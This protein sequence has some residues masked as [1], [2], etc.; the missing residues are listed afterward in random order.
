MSDRQTEEAILVFAVPGSWFLLMFFAGY[1]T[2][3]TAK[4]QTYSTN[5]SAIRLTGPFVTMIY[6]MITGDMLT[7]GIIYSI[8]LFGFSQ[9]FYFLYK[10]FPNKTTLYS[11]YFSTWMA[12]FQITLGNYDVRWGSSPVEFSCDYLNILVSRIGAD[13]VSR[14]EQSCVW[15]LHGIRSHFVVE[16]AD[17]DD[18]EHVRACYWTERE[19]VDETGL[20]FVFKHFK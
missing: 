5:F 15:V 6:S 1:F 18:G 19:G 4:I 3:K 14:F 10:G 12:L 9:S 17:C 8:V 13:S 20:E 11:N 7:F 2:A 16:H